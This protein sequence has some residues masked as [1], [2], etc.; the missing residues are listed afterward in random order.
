[1][2]PPLIA[3]IFLLSPNSVHTL[4]RISS[5]QFEYPKYDNVV[6]DWLGRYAL[7]YLGK[8]TP[9]TF[10]KMPNGN[11]N[12]DKKEIESQIY[13]RY[14]DFIKE[15]LEKVNIGPKEKPFERFDHIVWYANK[16]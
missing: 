10:F 7:A 5:T 9:E 11:L 6:S 3:L 13:R 16:G 14:W 2:A 8:E 12:K 15:I 4:L 1:M